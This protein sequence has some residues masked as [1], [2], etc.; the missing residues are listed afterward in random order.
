[1]M[2]IHVLN[3]DKDSQKMM[4]QACLKFKDIVAKARFSYIKDPNESPYSSESSNEYQRPVKPE[5][6][7]AIKEYIKKAIFDEGNRFPVIFPTAM[8]LACDFED[9][10]EMCERG[11]DVYMNDPEVFYIVDGQH[12]LK[13]MQKLYDEA[14][15][16][17]LI[18]EDN[19]KI[20]DFLDVFEFNCTILF[21]L[22]MWEQGQVFIDVNFNQKSVNRSLFYE[23]YGMDYYDRKD[24]RD[25]ILLSHLMVKAMNERNISPL[26]GFVK[27]LGNGKGLFS[28]ACLAEAIIIHMSSPNGIWYIDKDY[29]SYKFMTIELLSFYQAVKDVF[30]DMW[31]TGNPPKHRSIICKTTG[32]Q[33]MVRLMGCLHKENMADEAGL[34]EEMKKLREDQ[35]YPPYY[36]KIVFYLKRLKPFM[37]LL[38]GLKGPYAKTGGRGLA[39][40]LYKTMKAIINGAI[41]S[42]KEV[43]T[44]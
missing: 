32:I 33:A 24:K 39:M 15:E 28:Q 1:M 43:L 30:P 2:K 41:T 35:I 23:I 4:G 27:M 8:L 16:S 18:N 20:R 6:I 10:P 29:D 21:N 3:Y 38:F 5:R 12:R 26:K 40:K 9:I 25:F 36:E 44:T 22:D 11:K 17:L 14:C 42:E 7:K 13:S 19:K 37:E 34:F 31:P